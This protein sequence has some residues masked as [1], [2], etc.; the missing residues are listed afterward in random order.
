M[1]LLPQVLGQTTGYGLQ[2]I[3]RI[4][5]SLGSPQVRHEKNPGSLFPQPFQSGKT[6]HNAGIVGDFTVLHGDVEVDPNQDSLARYIEI[7]QGELVHGSIHGN[8]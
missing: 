3:A 6:G 8:R 4:R 2:G 5:A 1:N 7:V